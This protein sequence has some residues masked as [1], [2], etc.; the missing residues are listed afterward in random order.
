MKL[1]AAKLGFNVVEVPIIF[2]DR[3]EGTSKM[4]AGI[5]SEAIVG[6][7]KLRFKKIKPV[8]AK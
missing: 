3:K 8:E 4:S 7:V 5:F 1:T 2:T 6:V